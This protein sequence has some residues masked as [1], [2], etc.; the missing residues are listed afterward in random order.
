MEGINCDGEGGWTRVGY[1]NMSQSG[2]TC[3]TGLPAVTLN[4]HTLCGKPSLTLLPLCEST[5]FSTNNITYSK[6]CGQ[7]RGYQIKMVAAFA[8]LSSG[9]ESAYVNGISIT[10][11]SNPRKHI[12]TYA[13][14]L[15]ENQTNNKGCPCN[16]NY[17]GGNISNSFVG[18]DYYCE[19]GSSVYPLYINDPLWDG[20]QCNDNEASC[21][22]DDSRMPWFYRSLGHNITDDIEL[23]GCS[24]GSFEAQ[25]AVDIVELYIK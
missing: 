4:N 12:W 18:F 15:A 21:C 8:Y 20:E 3:P 13:G 22:P 1:L 5:I 10:H 25:T 17:T 23:R 11:G 19:S 7:V 2:A 6:V 9:I 24:S 14:G 16:I